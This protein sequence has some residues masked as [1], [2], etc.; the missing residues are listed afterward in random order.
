[1]GSKHFII[2]IIIIIIN[3]NNNVHINQMIGCEA[4]EAL[5]EF[6]DRDK[7]LAQGPLTNVTV[8]VIH[9]TR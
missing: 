5:P 4:S 3:N 7:K 1:M 8:P 2:I 6:V 9:E